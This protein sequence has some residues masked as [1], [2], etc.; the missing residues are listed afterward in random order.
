MNSGIL[1][2]VLA[3][4]AGLSLLSAC[5]GGSG[6]GPVQGSVSEVVQPPVVV[7]AI[8]ASEQRVIP[9]NEARAYRSE[10]QFATALKD[11][12]LADN[13]NI[14][15]LDVLPY[16]GQS[17][18]RPTTEDV[19]QRVVVTHDWMGARFEQML[20]RMPSDM[21][22]LFAPVTSIVIGS[23]VRPSSYSGTRARIS[24]DPVYLWVTVPEK[25][26]KIQATISA[27]S[28]VPV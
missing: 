21:L 22:E 5:G 4:L 23:Q 9:T 3:A 14:C 26:T 16:I 11:C 15:T 8:P 7:Q 1:P 27:R 19:M 12:A 20:R 24:I 13:E 25:R 17:G 2:N 10:G 18:Q 28:L 6:G